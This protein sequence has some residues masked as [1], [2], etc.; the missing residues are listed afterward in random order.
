MELTESRWET[1]LPIAMVNMETCNFRVQLLINKKAAREQQIQNYHKH[2]W[3]PQNF[4]KNIDTSR[5][6]PPKSKL[7]RH[8][9]KINSAHFVE[10]YDQINPTDNNNN[11][12]QLVSSHKE[13]IREEYKEEE[14]FD[15][16][17]DNEIP[18]E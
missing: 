6:G 4:F 16:A 8:K 17:V 2:G 12:N 1:Y 3:I 10:S 9:H 11:S 5:S 13:R 14:V 18:E 7:V 15:D